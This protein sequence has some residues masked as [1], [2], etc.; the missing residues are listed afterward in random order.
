MYIINASIYL[1]DTYYDQT[2][3]DT[4]GTDPYH[5]VP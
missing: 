2:H 4:H 5:Q 1:G 3:D